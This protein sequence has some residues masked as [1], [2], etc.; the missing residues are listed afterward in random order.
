MKAYVHAT[1]IDATGA[2]PLPDRTVLVE[3]G[4][5]AAV[6][7]SSRTP[8]PEGA[9][10]IDLTGRYL[11]P[12]L[13]DAHT[14]SNG[15]ERI[16]PALY[17]LMGV[18][19]VREM[20]GTEETRRLRDR[21]EA[22]E[23][24]GPRWS[25]AGNLIDGAPSLWGDLPGPQPPTVVAGPRE[26]RRAVNE[27]KDEGADFVKVYSRI[28]AESYRALL[29]EARRLDIPV[30]GHRSDHVPFA[31]QIESGQR[32]FEH[33]HGLWPATSRDS[34]ALEA[35]MARIRTEP[36]THYS[37]WFQQVNAVEWEAANTYGPAESASV[38][39]RMV[40]NDVAYC[41]TLVMHQYLDLPE[42]VRLTDPRLRYAPPWT[43]Q[44]W[45]SVLDEVYLK[46]RGAAEGAKRRV[47]FEMRRAAVAAMDDA[48]VR[49]LAGTDPQAPGVLPGFGLHQEL[50]LMV[51]AGLTPMRALQTATIEPA[52]F[53]GR[54]S[55]SG[56]VEPGK[57][58]D[59]LILDA[60]PLE[61]IGNTARIH[62]VVTRGRH[63]GPAE[64][65]ALLA[66]VERAAAGDG[67]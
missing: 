19:A 27:T 67:A 59:L 64:R 46:R 43:A 13:T 48:G 21:V 54:E 25:I 4:V 17:V 31:E 6:G 2:P 49:L 55:R 52:R 45:S 12:G 57:V 33:V 40:A 32:S 56:T 37:S 39:G 3:D 65:E 44:M 1:V 8:V 28:D 5:I 24:L 58:A 16:I 38:F 62:A 11:L 7:P 29:D 26:A 18:T 23:L 15:D 34:E 60:D 20:W 66:E 61:D 42:R 36:D 41:P 14:H 35:A 63:I 47:L 51:G 9:E 10:T 30:A 22:G 53:L 50:E